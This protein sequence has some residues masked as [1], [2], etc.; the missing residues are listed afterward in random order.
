MLDTTES[1]RL[2]RRRQGIVKCLNKLYH[3][4]NRNNQ[5]AIEIQEQYTTPSPAGIVLIV[6]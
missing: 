1:K 3:M 4:E 6:R 5:V 2:K